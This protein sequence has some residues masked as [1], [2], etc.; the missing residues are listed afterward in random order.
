MLRRRHA[1]HPAAGYLICGALSW[2]VSF[3]ASAQQLPEKHALLIGIDQ[4]AHQA[5]MDA[6]GAGIPTLKFAVRDADR[7]GRRLASQGYKTTILL[8]ENATRRSIV[9]ALLRIS[10]LAREEDTFILYYAG[11]G[12]RRQRTNGVYWLNYDGDPDL[13]DVDGL[14]VKTLIDLVNDIPAKRKLVMLDHCYA[15]QLEQVLASAGA[16]VAAGSRDTEPPAPRFVL[17]RD[18]TPIPEGLQASINDEARGMVV[19]AASRGL[20]F[21]LSDNQHG[22][23]TAALLSAITTRNADLSGQGAPGGDGGLSISEITSYLRTEVRRLSMLKNF[24][25]RPVT[26]LASD[27]DAEL[28]DWQPLMRNLGTT[29]VAAAAERYRAQLGVWASQNR[30]TP[31]VQADCEAVL[32][33]W[34]QAPTALSPND[35][36]IVFLLRNFIDDPPAAEDAL[37]AASL[38]ERVQYLLGEN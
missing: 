15:G 27:N 24:D 31:Q 22:V 4:Y 29:E 19:I 12:V 28:L 21:E 17:A 37:I 14:R 13:P 7:L 25:Q 30:I 23:F 36:A 18:A 38:S 11:H 3:A 32:G 10:E 35:E 33:R 6:R 5:K 20:A 9:T 2:L 16:T 34:Q 26:K 1:S 8:D